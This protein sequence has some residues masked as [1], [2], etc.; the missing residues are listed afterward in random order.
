MLILCL[1][2]ITFSHENSIVT[3]PYDHAFVATYP[4][5]ILRAVM[6][7]QLSTQVSACYEILSERKSFT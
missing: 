3:I 1:C 6:W 4:N 5:T 7:T 2:Y